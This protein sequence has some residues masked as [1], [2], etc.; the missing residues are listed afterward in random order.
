MG[1]FEIRVKTLFSNVIIILGKSYFA[2]RL[3]NY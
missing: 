1:M 2:D 3:W